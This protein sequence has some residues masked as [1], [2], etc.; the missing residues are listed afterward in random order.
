M[1]G[2]SPVK[3]RTRERKRKETPPGF[4]LP[5]LF[6]DF[7]CLDKKPTGEEERKA[8]RKKEKQRRET[9]TVTPP[10][11]PKLNTQGNLDVPASFFPIAR[12]QK[13][14]ISI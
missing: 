2:Y 3:G 11:C 4:L 10:L 9:A 6:S 14:I 1:V 7:L 12:R 13:K 8:E 5:L